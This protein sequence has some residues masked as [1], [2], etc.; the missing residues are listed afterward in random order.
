MGWLENW[1]QDDG[2]VL[3]LPHS[4]VLD[5]S[6][7]VVVFDGANARLSTYADV[8]VDAIYKSSRCSWKRCSSVSAEQ[9]E[10]DAAIVRLVVDAELGA[11]LGSEGYELA[12]EMEEDPAQGGVH[13]V[14]I[15]GAT[16]RAVLFGVGRLLR[17]INADYNISYSKALQGVCYVST[18]HPRIVSIPQ[19]SMRQHQV[20]YRPKTNSYDAF[21]PEMMRKEILD[22]ALF[23]CNAIEVIPPGID[24]ALQSPQFSVSWMEMLKVVSEWCDRL[25]IRLSIWYP[26]YFS[27]STEED[28]ANAK[29]HWQ[30]I[31]SALTR[32]DALFVPGGDPG[33]RP[34]HEF[35]KIVEKQAQFLREEF[36]PDCEIWVSSQYGLSVSYDLGTDVW[37]ELYILS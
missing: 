36:F 28:M 32:L 18:K 35:F 15:S 5:L 23:G 19:Y 22:L 9:P 26:A 29:A 1:S 25:D 7:A 21:T 33:G 13:K 8:L 16:D 30:S 6:K 4:D 37:G 14:Y 11:E 2:V 12:L 24:D 31:F 10:E 17:E 34:A 20:A 27:Y 3:A